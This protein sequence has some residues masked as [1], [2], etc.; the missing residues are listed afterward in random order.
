[1]KFSMTVQ[2]KYLLIQV[3]AFTVVVSLLNI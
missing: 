2:E 1:M 3:A